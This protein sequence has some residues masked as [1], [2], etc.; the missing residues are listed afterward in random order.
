LQSTQNHSVLV[1]GQDFED[2]RGEL[3]VAAL[4]L[5]KVS[6][7]SISEIELAREVSQYRK[8]LTGLQE[9]LPLVYVRLQMEK[10]RLEVESTHKGA[11]AAWAGASRSTM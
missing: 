9:I 10:A 2:L 5:R 11:A 1:T 6:P 4:W 7:E 8:L 3:T